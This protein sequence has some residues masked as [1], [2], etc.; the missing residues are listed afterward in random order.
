MSKKTN[1]FQ[2]LIHHIHNKIENT[3]AKVTESAFLLEKNINE[4]VE[5][6]IDVLIEKEV[7]GNIA[8]I[9]VECRDRVAKDDI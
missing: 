3:S 1:A 4:P 5:R 6:E 9:A 8:K 2:K 7:N